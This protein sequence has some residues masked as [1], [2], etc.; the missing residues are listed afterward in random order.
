MRRFDWPAMLRAGL[1][2]LGLR[3]AEFWGL[4]PVELMVMLGIEGGG[5]GALSR[6]GLVE[7]SRRFPDERAN[8]M[9]DDRQEQELA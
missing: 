7:L 8:G 6:E 5:R 3:P 2:G 4:T 1:R 9:D